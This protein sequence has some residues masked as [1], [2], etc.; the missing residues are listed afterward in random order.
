MSRKQLLLWMCTHHK[1]SLLSS[2]YFQIVFY[3]KKFIFPQTSLAENAWRHYD[4]KLWRR[5]NIKN[6]ILTQLK[7]H[8]SPEAQEFVNVYNFSYRWVGRQSYQI[9]QSYSQVGP[10]VCFSR[11][12]DS[13]WTCKKHINWH[14]WLPKCLPR[15]RGFDWLD[16]FVCYIRL[17]TST[18]RAFNVPL[19]LT[20]FMI[21]ESWKRFH[22]YQLLL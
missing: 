8:N 15:G 12:I 7:N 13:T 1:T 19:K 9:M 6:E 10:F 21:I 16:Y 14:F 20:L 18:M 17:H 11:L 22:N 3:E 5:K 2:S 4:I